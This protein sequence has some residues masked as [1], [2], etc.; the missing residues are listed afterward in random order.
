M[1]TS[2]QLSVVLPAFNAERYIAGALRSVLAQS[3]QNFELIV[4]DDGSTDR[5][6]SIIRRFAERDSRVRH[7]RRP[8]T[9]IVGALNDGLAA[10][11]APLVARMD[12]DDFALPRR[13]ETQLRHFD[14]HPECVGLGSAVDFIDEHGARVM[15]CPR[16]LGHEEIE[17]GLLRGDGG[18]IIHP[19][20]MFRREALFSIGGY[21]PEAQY[22]EDLDLYLRLARVGRLANLPDT[23]LQYRIHPGSINFT[24][25]AN[26]YQTKLGV[27]ADA[28]RARGL[29]FRNA[30]IPDRSRAWGTPAHRYREWA[31]TALQFGVRRVAVRHGIAACRLEPWNRQSWRSLRYALTAPI[32]P[33]APT[34]AST[35]TVA[36]AA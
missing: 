28:Y 29:P 3:F 10:A 4:V 18:M 14:A 26:R 6:P 20:A 24:K 11:Q 25:N 30:D 16:P 7:I 2:L 36:P 5:T 15:S 8:N 22:V 19:A 23:L 12:A 27:M 31:A 1:K 33:P 21:R 13:F 9:G 35:A 32:R 34:P 17:A